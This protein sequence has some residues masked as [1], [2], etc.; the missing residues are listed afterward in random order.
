MKVAVGEKVAGKFQYNR[1]AALMNNPEYYQ[2]S[3]NATQGATGMMDQ[4]NDIYIESI[5]GRLNTLQAAGEQ[6]MSTLFDQDNIAPV[7]ENVTN[8]VNG[9][10]TV[11]EVAGGGIPVFTALSALLLKTFSP[12]IAAQITQIA[13]NMA[14]MTQASNNMKNMQAAMNLAGQMGQGLDSRTFEVANKA[15][16]VVTG[17]DQAAQEKMTALVQQMAEAENKVVIA[18]NNINELAAQL[19][20]KYQQ[21]LHLTEEQAAELQISLAN[22]IKNNESQ[23]Q[24]RASVAE[25]LNLQEED[26]EVI[27]LTRTE[28]NN[29]AQSYREMNAAT[30]SVDANLRA[31][32]TA[33]EGFKSE[34]IARGF[35]QALSA[36]TSLV[37]TIQ[38]FT[39][40]MSILNSDTASFE[41]KFNSVLISGTMMVSMLGAT[42]TSLKS[43]FDAITTGLLG[44]EHA[45]AIAAQTEA[46]NAYYLALTELTAAQDAYNIALATGTPEEIVNAEARVAAATA[47]K[48]ETLSKVAAADSEVVNTEATV[49]NTIAKAKEVL[50]TKVNTAATAEGTIANKLYAISAK[51]LG[52]ASTEA[53]VASRTLALNIAM[54][55][56]PIAAVVAAVGLAV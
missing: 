10:N 1:F 15:V 45:A 2:K 43:S 56:A 50:A 41:E 30:E 23:D 44:A 21:R 46:V 12:Q 8:L 6:V 14:T 11:I 38:S 47:A 9:L 7:I 49:A 33:I 31:A 52:V 53:A 35:T 19:A 28:V 51:V 5:E 39:S 27:R 20:T 16:P 3:L 55:A 40:L 18:E 34:Q 26:L 36:A 4:M 24:I 17:L 25:T 32:D 54:I 37:F 13:T 29:I 22:N 48:E 42:A